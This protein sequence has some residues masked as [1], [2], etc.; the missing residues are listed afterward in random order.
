MSLKEAAWALTWSRGGGKDVG[1]ILNVVPTGGW[2]SILPAWAM[3]MQQRATEDVGSQGQ[4]T[5]GG[6]GECGLYV[7]LSRS[8]MATEFC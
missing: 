3:L 2:R 5:P 8:S 7:K 1:R 6:A 4:D